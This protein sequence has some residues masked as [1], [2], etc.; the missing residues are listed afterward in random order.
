MRLDF[1]VACGERDP[2][3]LEHRH[4]VPRSAGGS[5]DDASLLLRLF[6]GRVRRRRGLTIWARHA[7]PASEEQAG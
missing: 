6:I 1:C 7:W 3:S 4:L 2:A 5:D